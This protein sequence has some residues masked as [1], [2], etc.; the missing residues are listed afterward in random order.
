MIQTFLNRFLLAL[1]LVIG[2]TAALAPAPAAAPSGAVGNGK[3]LAAFRKRFERPHV[4]LAPIVVSTE[5]RD[6][7]LRE[8]VTV[9]SEAGAYCFAMSARPAECGRMT[10]TEP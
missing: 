4:P 5:A 8:K 6:G 2:L 3:L 7:L 10:L 1:V 9:A